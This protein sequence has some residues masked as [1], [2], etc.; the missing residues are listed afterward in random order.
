MT[1]APIA[2]GRAALTAAGA[3]ATSVALA[4]LRFTPSFAEH[5]GAL[6][7][8]DAA[9]ADRVVMDVVRL[10]TV[11]LAAWVGVVAI[12]AL[13]L[14]VSPSRRVR[15]AWQRLSP[16]LL[17]RLLTVGIATSIAA[18]CAGAGAQPGDES[19]A[20]IPVLRDLGDAPE[21]PDDLVVTLIDIGEAPTTVRPPDQIEPDAAIPVADVAEAALEQ[22]TVQRGD[23]LW[24]I[25]RA[26]LADRGHATD[27][28]TIERYW[29]RLIDSNRAAI[30]PDEDLV[31]PGLVL[32][33][34]T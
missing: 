8:W 28:A 9:G 34:P 11:G 33:L 18:S 31:H 5:P 27:D 12:L 1:L 3:T 4:P 22:W 17:R 23:H 7:W 10:A 32:M 20:P 2:R 6:E 29:R 13:I 14:S 25:A 26:T 24:S 21:P 15:L 30:G 19:I 16:A